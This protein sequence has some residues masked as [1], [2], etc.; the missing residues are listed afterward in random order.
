MFRDRNNPKR[1]ASLAFLLSITWVGALY[2]DGIVWDLKWADEFNNCPDGKPDPSNWKFE[3]GFVRNNELQWYQPANA[4]CKGGNLVIEAK[5]VYNMPNPN[6]DPS[7]KDWK[8]SRKWINYTSSSLN[9]NGKH[10]FTY[11]RFDIRAKID[12]RQGSW[13][14]W[15]AL[16]SKGGWPKN[17]EIDM[18]EYYRGKVLA[19]FDYADKQ[20]HS[21]WSSKTKPV[22]STWAASFHNWTMIWND[23]TIEL[24]LDGKLMNTFKISTADSGY[25]PNPWR[26]LP[27]YLLVNQAIGG[28]NGGDPSHTKFPISYELDYVRV[29]S[30]SLINQKT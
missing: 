29:Y 21:V 28:Q 17:G 27:S 12:I 23:K 7:S 30:G 9:T 26:D 18:M 13:P 22:D 25:S 4:Y 15:W 5:R 8:K 20:G 16:G 14:A 2:Q 10:Q 6:Y 1:I 11:G 24:Q 3:K 19:N